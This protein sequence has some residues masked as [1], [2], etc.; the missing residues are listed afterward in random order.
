M[1]QRRFKV[2]LSSQWNF[3]NLKPPPTNYSNRKWS[4][5]SIQHTWPK[6]PKHPDFIN[7]RWTKKNKTSTELQQKSVKKL[8]SCCQVD[9]VMSSPG[10]GGS[11]FDFLARFAGPIA[12][13]IAG[14]L[15]LF[16][17]LCLGW[18]WGFTMCVFFCVSSPL[19]GSVWWKWGKVFFQSDLTTWLKISKVWS[20]RCGIL[21]NEDVK[22]HHEVVYTETEKNHR[23]FQVVKGKVEEL[24]PP[25]LPRCL[26]KV[27][28]KITCKQNTAR[29]VG[30][31]HFFLLREALEIVGRTIFQVSN[32]DKSL[33]TWEPHCTA[34]MENIRPKQIGWH[35]NSWDTYFGFLLCWPK[36]FVHQQYEELKNTEIL[37]EEHMLMGSLQVF[38][39][40][41]L[42]DPL[43]TS[44]TTDSEA[45][46]NTPEFSNFW[47]LVH[48]Y[49]K[50]TQLEETYH[51]NSI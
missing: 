19:V 13:L 39:V 26:W 8:L 25:F 6:P 11:P 50:T 16:G 48:F 9:V 46:K 47:F 32:L 14:L 45:S 3:Q 21:E 18:H 31:E 24:L 36:D 44:E 7:F 30:Y 27:W 4:K 15:L 22:D 10:S 1:I 49:R 17:G 29:G 51:V 33:T 41:I 34:V 12:W 20:R 38:L 42:A 43:W 2:G 37:P 40:C 5:K 35:C 23:N 28:T